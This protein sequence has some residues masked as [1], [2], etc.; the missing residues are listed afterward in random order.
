MPRFAFSVSLMMAACC[1]S[2]HLSADEKPLS[3]EVIEALKKAGY[4]GIANKVKRME[5]EKAGHSQSR[6]NQV[7]FQIK[8][9]SFQQG[10]LKAGGF[11]LLVLQEMLEK[12]GQAQEPIS[13]TDDSGILTKLFAMM[14]RREVVD[15]LSEPK[16]IT[17]D[18]KA[19]Q[20]EIQTE[21]AKEED[22]NLKRRLQSLKMKLTPRLLSEDKLNL[23][24]SF[25]TIW[26]GPLG[27]LELAGESLDKQIPLGRTLLVLAAERPDPGSQGLSLAIFI[28]CDNAKSIV[29]R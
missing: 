8:V 20:F 11:N 7:A 18:Q 25:R 28:T 2:A 9:Y 21:K 13:L 4:P 24:W 29:R 23:L 5:Q 19:A 1:F 17:L 6:E 16:I 12:A 10:R 26:D 22:P 27:K 3:P 14:H 15:L